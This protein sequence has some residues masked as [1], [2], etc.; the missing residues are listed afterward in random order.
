MKR[1]VFDEA[2][3][4]VR[5]HGMLHHRV[6][7]LKFMS[8]AELES[9]HNNKTYRKRAVIFSAEPHAEADG[10]EHAIGATTAPPGDPCN[11]LCGTL[12]NARPPLPVA[13]RAVGN[14]KH[15]IVETVHKRTRQAENKV[16][17]NKNASK[18]K[19]QTDPLVSEYNT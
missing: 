7:Q 4:L 15:N 18:K 17:I 6:W 1:L 2:D 13:I 5:V 9:R 8:A 12:C 14:D 16:R 11:V 3:H 10:V 19:N